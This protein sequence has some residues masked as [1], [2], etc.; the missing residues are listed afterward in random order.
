MF[1]RQ[2]NKLVFIPDQFIKDF[3]ETTVLLNGFYVA[4]GVVVDRINIVVPKVQT[5]TEGYVWVESP[6]AIVEELK[7]QLQRVVLSEEVADF[8][9]N[10]FQAR[11]VKKSPH[12]ATQEQRKAE[13]MNE[14]SALCE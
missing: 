10:P 5:E 12:V 14:L 11:H 1:I 2:Q 13:L 4:D 8:I 3:K 9:R 6:E 7:H